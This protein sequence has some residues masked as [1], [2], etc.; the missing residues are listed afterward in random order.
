L[1]EVPPNG[2]GGGSQSEKPDFIDELRR[3]ESLRLSCKM[4]V[5]VWNIFTSRKKFQENTCHFDI[6]ML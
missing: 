2:G 5:I 4:T 3:G 1:G 6:K